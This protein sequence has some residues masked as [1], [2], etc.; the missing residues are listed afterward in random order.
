VLD[1][2][3]DREFEVQVR[4]A[5]DTLLLAGLQKIANRIAAAAVLAA[6]IIGASMLM[7]VETSFLILGYPGFAM[8]LFLAAAVGGLVL[9]ADVALHDRWTRR[10]QPSSP[11]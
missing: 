4:V 11:T 7:R 2:V 9:L 10:A 3:A 6:L 5:N 8:I 1:A